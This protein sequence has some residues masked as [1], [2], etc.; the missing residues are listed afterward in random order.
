VLTA[1]G[2]GW[3]TTPTAPPILGLADAPYW[4]NREAVEAKRLPRSLAV[5]GGGA[6]GVELAQVY[7]RFGV[8]VTVLEAADR[9][10]P[11][12]EPD[13]GALVQ[14]AL[15]ADG[16]TVHVG[17]R[18]AKVNHDDGVFRVDLRPAKRVRTWYDRPRSSAMASISF[19][20]SPRCPG[21]GRC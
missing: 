15:T 5:I 16:V 6:V 2:T 19:D 14:E 20:S 4:T 3:N 18:I 10:L 1:A 13:A 21:L 17:A 9:L 8:E 11:L 12:E 7:A